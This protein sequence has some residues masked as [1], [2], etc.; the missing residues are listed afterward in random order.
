M[1][2]ETVGPRC[3]QFNAPACRRASGNGDENVFE[4]HRWPPTRDRPGI[5]A[6]IKTI[7]NG[8]RPALIHVRY[9]AASIGHQRTASILPLAQLPI[10]VIQAHRL[11]ALGRPG[12]AVDESTLCRSEDK[13]GDRHLTGTANMLSPPTQRQAAPARIHVLQCGC[14]PAR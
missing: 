12:I 14:Y 10:D 8:L 2:T 13:D 4:A 5:A 3:C 6:I 9:S 1:R 11:F 7:S